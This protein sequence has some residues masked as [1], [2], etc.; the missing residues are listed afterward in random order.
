MHP[1]SGLER[2]YMVRILGAVDDATL[3]RLRDGL[4]LDDGPARF[5]SLEPAGGGETNR[6]FRVLVR[7]G[8][9]RLVR[10]LW[11]AAGCQVSRL[12]R[13]R[14]GPVVL[15][16]DLRAGRHRLLE[17]DG[18]QALYVAAGL[19]GPDGQPGGYWQSKVPPVTP[20]LAGP[21]RKR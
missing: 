16:R 13:V 18:L 21:S 11:E 2:E 14:Y 7:E 4:Q 17:G 15:P 6:W 8:R 20:R 3:Q 9:N 10:R 5:D 1:S 19:A 12:I